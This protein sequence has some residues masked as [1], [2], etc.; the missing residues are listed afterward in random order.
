MRQFPFLQFSQQFQNTGIRFCAVHHVVVVMIFKFFKAPAEM[1][2]ALS[3]GDSPLNEFGVAV[4]DKMF[5]IILTYSGEIIQSQ[6]EINA[7]GQIAERI[8]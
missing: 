8:Q 5:G 1:R 6:R 7:V 3:A 2:I 4:A